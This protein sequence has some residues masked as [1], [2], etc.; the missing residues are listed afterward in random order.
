MPPSPTQT[1]ALAIWFSAP[2]LWL[3]A[4][5]VWLLLLAR[6]QLRSAS[7]LTRWGFV[8]FVV[9]GAAWRVWL[10]PMIAAT[11]W[12]WSRESPL[13]LLLSRG[14]VLGLLAEYAPGPLWFDDV[15]HIVHLVLAC[16]TPIAL[17]AHGAA[18]L[19]D[20]RTAVIAA[21]L[22]AM[23]PHH[24]RFAATD[25]YFIP[26]LWLS[27][28]AFAAVYAVASARRWFSQAAAIVALLLLTWLTLAARPLNILF[29]PLLLVSA[30]MASEGKKDA[31]GRLLV[32][33]ACILAPGLARLYSMLT[34]QTQSVS[35]GLS[36]STLTD[37]IRL[38]FRP[39]HNPMTAWALTPP[40]WTPLIAWGAWLTWR[41]D[42]R[43]AAFLLA[44]LFGF[45]LAHGVVVPENPGMNA[46][47]QL[48]ALAPM[49]LLAAPAARRLAELLWTARPGGR[50]AAVVF[51]LTLIV[52]PLLH[53]PAIEDTTAYVQQEHLFYAQVR[54]LASDRCVVIERLR[55][56]SLGEVTPRA[57]RLAQH[58]GGRGPR[59]RSIALSQEVETAMSNGVGSAPERGSSPRRPG[60]KRP[61]PSVV[62]QRDAAE[63]AAEN[64]AEYSSG[65]A[66]R[67][68]EHPAT[69]NPDIDAALRSDCV[70]FL[71][72]VACH[73]SRTGPGR[74]PLCARL[75]GAAKWRRIAERTL[76]MRHWDPNFAGHLRAEG[77]PVT[78]RI[79]MR[80]P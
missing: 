73:R 11:A 29:V 44:W 27:S 37:G 50:V 63:D 7:R 54:A 15:V 72:G 41:A 80:Q 28:S 40:L 65:D 57:P 69:W 62:P 17:F 33:A 58:I 2:S 34:V 66:H 38:L 20:P 26:S 56:R 24:I 53:R 46:R 60:A 70:L 21:G 35:Q 16:L 49:V 23:S 71:E 19:K 9:L 42:R 14:P 13:P 43:R 3:L 6:H 79:W 45:I 10:S 55:P 39:T 64:T 68:I 4:I 18:L 67:F 52:A 74:D 30:W 61:P 25:A 77:Q 47:Y 75:L 1:H 78:L 32:I 8:G 51:G 12:S 5:I 22:L 31:R 59:W 76:P 48:H 36:L